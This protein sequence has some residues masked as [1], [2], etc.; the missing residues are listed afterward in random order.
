MFI[1]TCV[2][3]QQLIHDGSSE[4]RVARALGGETRISVLPVESKLVMNGWSTAR[5]AKTLCLGFLSKGLEEDSDG[6]FEQST[7]NC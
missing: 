7:L 6:S 1:K 4:G 2:R 5:L 3:A